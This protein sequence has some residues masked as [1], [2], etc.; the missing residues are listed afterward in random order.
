MVTPG[1]NPQ[2]S[3][4]SVWAGRAH[5]VELTLR[6]ARKHS[7]QFGKFLPG[8]RPC[9]IGL[10][11]AWLFFGHFSNESA[12][13]G[14]G[15]ISCQFSFASGIPIFRWWDMFACSTFGC[16]ILVGF[17][18]IL[19]FII[20]GVVRSILFRGSFGPICGAIFGKMSKN[21][22]F[23]VSRGCEGFRIVKSEFFMPFHFRLVVSFL[24]FVIFECSKF[25]GLAWRVFLALS[26]RRRVN[27]PQVQD[28]VGRL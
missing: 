21:Q 23:A 11:C 15:I 2:G 3:D 25:P 7:S 4:S 13:T 22:D 18:K 24:F 20:W 26:A 12:K 9:S 16:G 1:S 10:P 28:F 8:W 6:M 5:E 17:S 14:I 19:I 27:L